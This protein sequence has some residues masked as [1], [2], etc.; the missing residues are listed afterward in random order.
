MDFT[1]IVLIY[2]T[3]VL[4]SAYRFGIAGLIGCVVFLAVQTAGIHYHWTGNHILLALISGLAAYFTIL[5]L[6]H[7]YLLATGR[8]GIIRV[9]SLSDEDL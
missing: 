8:K 7:W 4:L 3:A 5:V 6:P 1:I 9:K 2:A